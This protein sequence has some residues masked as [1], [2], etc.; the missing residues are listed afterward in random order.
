[1]TVF[2]VR[3][4]GLILGQCLILPLSLIVPEHF[5]YSTFIPPIREITLAH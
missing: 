1:M 2:G 5:L 3:D 4:T